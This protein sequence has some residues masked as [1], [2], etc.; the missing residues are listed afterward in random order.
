SKRKTK[1]GIGSKQKRRFCQRLYPQWLIWS[2]GSE[3]AEF[4]ISLPLLV[5]LVVGIYDF[6]GAFTLKNKLNSAVQEGA[7]IASS[8]QTGN[9]SVNNGTCGA[10]V[11]ICVVR[12]IVAGSLTASI[13]NDC[14]LSTGTVT[15]DIVNRVWIFGGSCTNFTLKVERAVVNP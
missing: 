10:P 8:Q 9:L 3:L 7:R 13:G 6:G 14:G 15:P 1:V 4:A 11:S 12:D 5:V 2:E